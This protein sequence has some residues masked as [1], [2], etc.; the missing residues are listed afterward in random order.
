MNVLFFG[1]HPDDI[2]TFSGG[3]AFRYAQMGAKLFFCVATN[4]NVG[5]T[6]LSK[7][8]IAKVRKQE[9]LCAAKFIGAELIWL[10]FDDEFL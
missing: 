2:E 10:N 4:G 9:A 7:E 6:A 8:E 1:A 3:T 5:S